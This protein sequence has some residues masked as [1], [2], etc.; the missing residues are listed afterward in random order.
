MGVTFTNCSY[1]IYYS[2]SYSYEEFKQ[3][4]DRIHRIGQINKCTYIML[5]CNNTIDE[6]I[7]NCLQK[8]KNAVDELYQEMILEKQ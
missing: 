3:S 4:Q 7:Y 5:Q 2:Q 1:N 6:K 8:K